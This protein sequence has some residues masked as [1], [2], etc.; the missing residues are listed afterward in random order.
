MHSGTPHSRSSANLSLGDFIVKSSSNKKQRG[1]NKNRQSDS[2][3]LEQQTRSASPAFVAKAAKAEDIQEEKVEAKVPEKEAEPE[4]TAPVAA[5][6]LEDSSDPLP[7]A[8]TSP[9]KNV[10]PIFQRSESLTRFIDP[11][12]LK[13]S[14]NV[15]FGAA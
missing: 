1:R 3:L 6:L 10:K 2:A 15:V 11:D 4:P 7:E 5:V 9:V 8:V 13:V 14:S 12:P